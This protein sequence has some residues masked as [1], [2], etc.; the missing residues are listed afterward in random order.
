MPDTVRLGYI[1]AGNI[2]THER[3]GHLTNLKYVPHAQV[4]AVSDVAPGRAESVATQFGIPHAYTNY[5]DL[6]ARDDIDAVTVLTPNYLHAPITIAALR[7][8]KHVLC[9][10]PM[11]LTVADAEAMVNTARETGK[12]LMIAFNNRFRA[13]AQSLKRFIDDGALGQVYFARTGWLRRS[14]IPGLGSWFTNKELSGGGVLLDLGP[15]MLDIALWMM[16][17]PKPTRVTASL[18][19]MFGPRGR[20]GSQV[21]GRPAQTTNFDVDDSA[22]AQVHFD[23]GATLNLEVSWASHIELGDDVFLH[24]WGTEGG[25]RM[26]GPANYRENYVRL[27]TEQSSQLVDLMPVLSTPNYP[28]PSHGAELAA[29]VDCLLNDTPVPASAEDGLTIVRLTDAM[30]RAANEGREVTL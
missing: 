20:G 25:A 12:K 30:V 23:N 5:E 26:Y 29:W 24:L 27:F 28:S 1:G 15:H 11:A 6:L 17:Y 7:A 9:E 18:Y 8:G 22:L 14:G 4:V 3:A 16:G 21:Y 13:D 19:S 2:A 10:K